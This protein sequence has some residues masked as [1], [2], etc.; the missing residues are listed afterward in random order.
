MSPRGRA[1]LRAPF[2]LLLALASLGA[3]QPVPI[4]EAVKN[5]DQVTLRRLLQQRT[6]VNVPE[7]DG[8]TALHWA[9]HRDDIDATELLI[10]AGATVKA[11]NRYGVAPLSLAAAHGNAAVIERLLGAGADANTTLAGGET[12]LMTAARTGTADAIRVLLAHGAHVNA[13]ESTRGQTALMW[14]AA[15]GH[16]GAIEVLVEA[17]AEI[18]ARA[19]GP[20]T[21]SAPPTAGSAAGRVLATRPDAVTPLLFAVRR[22][23]RDAVRVLLRAGADPNDTAPDGTS[24]VTV[25]IINWH[26]EVGALLLNHGAD[27]N[28]SAQGWTALHQLARFGSVT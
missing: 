22:G 18:H 5:G 20:P 10:R 16:A 1:R 25:A 4:V 12:A 17:G 15:E 9:A 28:A 14:A 13:R 7:A 24:A 8:T 11:T 27:P 2:V 19:T 23:H 6:D 3:G 26:Y 21:S